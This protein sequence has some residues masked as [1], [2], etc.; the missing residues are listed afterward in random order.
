M[1]CGE[2]ASA[3]D[4]IQ[5]DRLILY[6]VRGKFS[7][8]SFQQAEFPNDVACCNLVCHG[9]GV[10]NET[11]SY[12]GVSRAVVRGDGMRACGVRLSLRRTWIRQLADT[13]FE[14]SERATTSEF[15]YA[16]TS[17]RLRGR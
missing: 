13:P 3:A 9:I 7:V 12:S 14:N 1:T 4:A 17:P 11:V 8:F 10:F 16:L 6:K 2:C 5:R 15:R